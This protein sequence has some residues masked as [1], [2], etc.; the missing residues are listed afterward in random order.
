MVLLGG[1][2]CFFGFGLVGFYGGFWALFSV[3]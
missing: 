1:G 2:W 3:G